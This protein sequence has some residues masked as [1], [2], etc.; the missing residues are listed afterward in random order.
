MFE[1]PEFKYV[2]EGIRPEIVENAKKL[3]TSGGLLTASKTLGY[4]TSNYENLVIA[5]RLLIFDL[6]SKCAPTVVEYAEDYK[7]LLQDQYYTYIVNHSTQIQR[8]IDSRISS[9]YDHDY[10]SAANMK[11]N[12]MKKIPGS[13]EPSEHYGYA[14]FRVAIQIYSHDSFEKVVNCFHQLSRM[15]VSP[16]SPVWYNACFKKNYLS[17]CFLASIQDDMTDITYISS[18]VFSQVSKGCGAI[19]IDLSRLRHSE[20]AGGGSSSGIMPLI[21]TINSNCRY[22]DQVGHRKGSTTLNLRS[23]H[24]DLIEF[25]NVVNK[26]GDRYE[27]AH[28]INTSIFY[29]DIFIERVKAKAKWTLMCPAKTHWLND[30]HGEEFTREYIR[31]E[32][33]IEE[34]ELEYQK[35]LVEFNK[36]EKLD[37]L[38]VEGRRMIRDRKKKLTT[39]NINRIQH[40]VVNAYDVMKLIVDSHQ[41]NSMPY[42]NSCDSINFKAPQQ[43]LGYHGLP[44]LCQEIVLQ[45]GIDKFGNKTIASCNLSSIPLRKL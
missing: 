2:F 21:Q 30:L 16:P 27:T 24:L 44:N 36:A 7:E 6:R 38:T 43:N 18:E 8:H 3:I 10:F 14:C 31:T 41:K 9:D 4:D 12:Y 39:A 17:S 13:S 5:G 25:I 29:S 22:F 45:A 33:L 35:A 20:I 42:L 40:K 28:D 26:V 34:K 32:K 11:F 23:H 37:D 19:G 1:H 15:E